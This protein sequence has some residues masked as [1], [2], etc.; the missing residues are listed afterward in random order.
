MSPRTEI[1]TVLQ[2]NVRRGKRWPPVTWQQKCCS[3][4]KGFWSGVDFET[5]KTDYLAPDERN[6]VGPPASINKRPI[7]DG[8]PGG[9]APLGL[10]RWRAS[11]SRR[12][13]PRQPTRR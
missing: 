6:V 3:Q 12:G 9:V 5:S 10:R 7:V 13:I 1:H 4:Q 11:P 8:P 2:G